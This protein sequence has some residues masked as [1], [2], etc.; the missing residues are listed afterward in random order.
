VSSP[1]GTVLVTGASG[2]IG[3]HVCGRLL[4]AG[5]RVTGLTRR[6]DAGLVPGVEKAVGD[7]V[8]GAGLDAAC[9]GVSAVVH[10]VGIIREQ[11]SATFDKVHV[12]GA[13]NVLQAAAAAGVPRF[14]HMSALGAGPES[15]SA[16]HASKADAEALVREADCAWTIMRPSLVFGPG[17]DFFGGTLKELVTR[18]PV[19]PVVGSGKY[20]FRP[21]AVSDVADAF[22]R[23][24]GLPDTAGA[25]F[26]LA[27]PREYTLRE[28]LLLVR[29]TLGLK[30][31]LVNIPLPLMWLGVN[32][33]RLLPD[34]PVT[35][36]EFLMLLA[37]N[38]A[39]PGPAGEAFHL[40]L[41]PLEEHLPEILAAAGS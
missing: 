28:L 22:A 27:G 31:P 9:T 5:K 32:L 18:P 37:G 30:K 26:E 19:V 41:E 16:Y 34:P 6:A 21:V 11:G 17:D 38:T 2:F 39:D 29:D 12:S 24:A 15:G 1:A 20:P 8:T 3:R 23:A 36:D 40:K 13:R 10:L 4:A 14:V 25:T 7:V 33:F 35:R